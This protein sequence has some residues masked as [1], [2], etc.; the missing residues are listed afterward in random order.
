M[1]AHVTA[2][3]FIVLA[4]ILISLVYSLFKGMVREMFSL[5]SLTFGYLVALNFYNELAEKMSGVIS[6][7]AI[8]N[9]VAFFILFMGVLILVSIIG[10][11]VRKFLHSSDA[12]SGWDRLLGSLFGIVKGLVLVI[13]I[14]FPL[15]L[16][17]TLYKNMTHG[18]TLAPYLEDMV[19]ELRDRVDVDDDMMHTIPHKF[20]GLKDK[21]GDM[22][23][24]DDIKDRVRDKAE[25][26]TDLNGPPQEIYSEKDEEELEKLLKDLSDE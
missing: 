8:G 4:I 25:K 10:R 15:Q 1:R 26:Y 19:D 23:D 9:I 16:F 22:D 13:V 7:P 12:I 18:S 2:F 11:M 17:S 21:L 6:E 20:Q 3:D 24:L 14:M 5:L